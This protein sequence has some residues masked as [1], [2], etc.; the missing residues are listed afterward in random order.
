MVILF[1]LIELGS[2]RKTIQESKNINKVLMSKISILSINILNG[3]SILNKDGLPILLY[4]N[5]DDDLK[6]CLLD[7]SFKSLVISLCKNDAYTNAKIKC[8]SFIDEDTD[9]EGNEKYDVVE[10]NVQDLFSIIDNEI[11]AYRI[12]MYLL[13]D[14]YI[15]IFKRSI[16]ENYQD[17]SLDNIKDVIHKMYSA[18]LT[19][20]QDKILPNTIFHYIVSKASQINNLNKKNL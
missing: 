2:L 9:I 3:N 18:I 11:I 10:Y 4:L 19:N 6:K 1:H 14:L 8:V 15:N 16:N 7:D 17:N 20:K 12:I 5:K 13:H